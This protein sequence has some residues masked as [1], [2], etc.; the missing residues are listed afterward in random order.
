M[1]HLKELNLSGNTGIKDIK[2]LANL[3]HLEKDKT[4][5]PD[6]SVKDDL[7]SAIEV[8][9]L[10]NEFNISKMTK[11]NLDAVKKALICMRI[12]QQSKRTILNRKK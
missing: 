9:K 10:F 8:N 3:I 2:P 4:Y 11:E 7:F 1:K 5:L 12:L 6:N